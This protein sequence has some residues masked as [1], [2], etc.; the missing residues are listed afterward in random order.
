MTRQIYAQ[1]QIYAMECPKCKAYNLVESDDP[2]I[3]YQCPDPECGFTLLVQQ[4]SP[5]LST[6]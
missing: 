5:H 3:R 2:E 6:N 4:P 1:I